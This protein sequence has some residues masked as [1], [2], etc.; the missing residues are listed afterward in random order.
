MDAGSVQEPGDRGVIDHP[1]ANPHEPHLRLLVSGPGV[2]P[3]DLQKEAHGVEPAHR[4]AVD[5][6]PVGDLGTELVN[7]SRSSTCKVPRT[8]THPAG[9]AATAASGDP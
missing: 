3:D 5:A 1:V 6:C 7:A 2:L 4:D 8:A 9:A